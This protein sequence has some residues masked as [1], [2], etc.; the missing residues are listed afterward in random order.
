[1]AEMILMDEFHVS[2]RVS[3]NLN[4]TETRTIRATLDGARFRADL[5]RAVRAAFRHWPALTGVRVTI[6]R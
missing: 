3:R 2:V 6:T 1:M 4:E 5:G